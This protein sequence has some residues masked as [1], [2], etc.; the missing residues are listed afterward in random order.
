[1]NSG[2]RLGILAAIIAAAVV[3]LIVVNGGSN[4]DSSTTKTTV[5][6]TTTPSTTSTGTGGATA[7]TTT[8]LPKLTTITV[9]NARPVGGIKKIKVNKGDQIRFAV[10]SPDTTDEVHVHG[11]D[12]K[13]D[14][15]A[16]GGVVF[17]FPATI[18]G[19]FEV[20]LENRAEQIAQLTVEP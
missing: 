1:M 17:S 10:K 20:E 19:N 12:R 7:S 6:T 5:R 11:Y 9:K 3:V 18:D 13:A 8:P 15:K 2:T 4:N 14:L 16:G